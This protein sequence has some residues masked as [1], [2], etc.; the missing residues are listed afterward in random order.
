MKHMPRDPTLMKWIEE[1][2]SDHE[3]DDLEF[4]YDLY[5]ISICTKD[6]RKVDQFTEWFL[7]P[8]RTMFATKASDFMNRMVIDKNVYE[9]RRFDL[10]FPVFKNRVDNH[11]MLQLVEV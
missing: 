2:L 1:A 10:I 11:A 3:V 8:D 9:E 4:W 7:Q 5:I 6:K